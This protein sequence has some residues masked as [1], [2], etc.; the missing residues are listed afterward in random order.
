M[1]VPPPHALPGVLLHAGLHVGV[2]RPLLEAVDD[3]EGRRLVARPGKRD[4]QLTLRE[5]GVE[6]HPAL[7]AHV[8]RP[9]DCRCRLA[10]WW[11]VGREEA[12]RIECVDADG[13]QHDVVLLAGPELF[14]ATLLLDEPSVEP[15]NRLE[16]RLHEVVATGHCCLHARRA[17]PAEAGEDAERDRVAGL[18]AGKPGPAA[19]A[20]AQG[21][22]PVERGLGFVVGSRR[23]KE[24]RDAGPGLLLVDRVA[25][26][27]RL[28][29]QRLHEVGVLFQRALQGDSFSCG[30][31]PLPLLEDL[32]DPRIARGEVPREAVGIEPREERLGALVGLL[33]D[34]RERQ[35]GVPGRIRGRLHDE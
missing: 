1:L 13:R 27:G 20:I 24:E 34:R 2:D 9:L 5:P 17:E 10:L 18:P 6:L 8:K 26:P 22:Q 19:V 7:A 23:V 31:S 21:L 12:P 16:R 35:H 25:D 30:R 3:R 29:E 28:G 4:R 15:G 11:R 33:H 14:R 32:A